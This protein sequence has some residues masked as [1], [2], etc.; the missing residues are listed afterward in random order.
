M[1]IPAAHRTGTAMAKVLVQYIDDPYRIQRLIRA[2]FSEVPII[3]SI[4]AM[5]AKHLAPKPTPISFKTEE[6]RYRRSMERSNAAFLN[7]LRR[8]YG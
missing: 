2:E 8:T 1:D 4:K 3:E 5:R 6:D 7:A